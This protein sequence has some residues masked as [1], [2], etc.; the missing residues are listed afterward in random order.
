MASKSKEEGK[1]SYGSAKRGA[2]NV[3]DS[4]EAPQLGAKV[5]ETMNSA[6]RDAKRVIGPQAVKDAR[7]TLVSDTREFAGTI[8]SAA[9]WKQSKGTRQSQEHSKCQS[10]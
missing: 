7:N 1:N 3:G 2:K 10:C 6:G 8:Y 5:K 9:R 4:K